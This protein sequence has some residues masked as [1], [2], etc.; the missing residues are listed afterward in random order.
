[1]ALQLPYNSRHFYFK[2]TTMKQFILG[3]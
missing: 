1:V 2:V 3:L